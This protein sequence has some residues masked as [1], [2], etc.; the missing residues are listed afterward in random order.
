MTRPSHASTQ[1]APETTCLEKISSAALSR[2]KP[3]RKVSWERKRV[4]E[5]K[6]RF[7]MVT[8]LERGSIVPE[9]QSSLAGNLVA[10]QE[11]KK[12]LWLKR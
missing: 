12:G 3:C 7:G 10:V 4:E 8:E 6:K 11:A 2:S 5:G 9:A 1:R